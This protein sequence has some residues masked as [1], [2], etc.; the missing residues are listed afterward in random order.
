[1]AQKMLDLKNYK[2]NVSTQTGE[3]NEFCVYLSS[4]KILK[5]YYSK[6]YKDYVLSF[7]FGKSKKYI[8]TKSMWKILYEFLPKINGTLMDDRQ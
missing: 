8:I 7:N 6:S 3:I 1:M 2:I 4:C 5:L